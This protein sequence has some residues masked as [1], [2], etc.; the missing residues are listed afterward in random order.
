M[1]TA[2]SSISAMDTRMTETDLSGSDEDDE[3]EIEH[4][5]EESSNYWSALNL[6]AALDDSLDRSM[7]K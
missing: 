7:S 3:S 6:I 5:S 4:S 1:R 2:Q